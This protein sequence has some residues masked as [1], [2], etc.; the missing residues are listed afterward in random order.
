MEQL[1]WRSPASVTATGYIIVDDLTIPSITAKSITSDNTSITAYKKRMLHIHKPQVRSQVELDVISADL[2]AKHKDPKIT[3]E[4]LLEGNTNIRYTGQSL[5]VNAPPYG[6]A[7]DTKFRI[8][9]I[10]HKITLKG[11]GEAR[12]YEYTTSVKLIQDEVSG[13]Q[14]TSSPSHLYDPWA[15]SLMQMQEYQRQ[16][17]MYEEQRNNPFAY[18]D[19]FGKQDENE[20]ATFPT[21]PYEGMVWHLTTT[22]GSDKPG[23]YVYLSGTWVIKGITYLSD[24]T[25]YG[26]VEWPTDQMAIEVRPWSTNLSI[27]WDDATDE[28]PTDWNHIK[29]GAKGDEGS[30][31]TDATIDYS[32]GTTLTITAGETASVGDGNWWVYWDGT[33]TLRWTQTYGTASGT[34]K[35]IVA[36]VNVEDTKA[37]S[38]ITYN[39]YVPSAGFGSIVSHAINSKHLS[40]DWITGKNFR[41]AATVGEGGGPAGLRFDANGVIGYSGG[42]TK[43][44]EM[45]ASTGYFIAYGNVAGGSFRLNVG[46]DNYG[47][48]TSFLTSTDETV[49]LRG[50]D[51]LW[52]NVG[53][54]TVKFDQGGTIT[55]DDDF[56]KIVTPTTETIDIGDSTHLINDTYSK[57]YHIKTSPSDNEATGLIKTFEAGENLAIGEA[58]YLHDDTGT[59]AVVKKA[60]ADS[61][62]TMPCMGIA[63]EAITSGNSGKILLFGV[64][65]DSSSWSGFADPGDGVYVSEATAGALTTTQPSGSGELIQRA[66]EVTDDIGELLF[67]PNKYILELA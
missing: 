35:G 46:A 54:D 63:I 19:W 53:G 39:G 65:Y 2:L 3:L 22:S 55:I 17:E 10:Y 36:Q 20:G 12:D 34:G 61:Y 8:L 59:D 44:A 11:Q 5:D 14:Q 27:I 62:N 64:M 52:L 67:A 57:Q 9:D 47:W 40:A 16:W 24:G 4:L 13:T 15:W 26:T 1:H 56:T 33:S 41:T 21:D 43:T 31:G 38:I 18:L 29:W 51:Q 32:D 49:E 7:S 25:D 45:E 6:Y 30:G 50:D 28:P 42:A 60:K 23:V 48:L 37:P 58:V 66:G